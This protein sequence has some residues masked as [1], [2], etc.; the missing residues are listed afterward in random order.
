M[1]LFVDIA[2]WFNQ[3]VNPIA[4]ANIGWKYYL[5][6]VCF[7]VV[8]FVVVWKFFI[9]TKNT[10]LEEI[11]KY[12]DG[13]AAMVGGDV[14]TDKARHLAAGQDEDGAGSGEGP[15]LQETKS[16]VPVGVHTSRV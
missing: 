10:P 1:F 8:E 3:Y 16:E 6:Y 7:L 12:F 5:V 14:A 2:L 13:D 9:E 15:V 11:A 4:L